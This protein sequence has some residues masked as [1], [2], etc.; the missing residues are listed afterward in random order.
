MGAALRC[1]SVVPESIRLL[2]QAFAAA[3]PHALLAPERH[4]FFCKTCQ[5]FANHAFLRPFL[6]TFYATTGTAVPGRGIRSTISTPS[7]PQA[8]TSTSQRFLSQRGGRGGGG[9]KR[10]FRG[11]TRLAGGGWSIAHQPGPR[12][13]PVRRHRHGSRPQGG[14]QAADRDGRCNGLASNEETSAKQAEHSSS[15]RRTRNISAV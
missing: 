13:A 8:G 3:R 14:N 11:G 7:R 12:A 9:D 2:Q 1:A 10:H 4:A 15:S 6:N 5:Q